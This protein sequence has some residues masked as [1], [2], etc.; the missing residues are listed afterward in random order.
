MKSFSQFIHEM[1]LA[2]QK[3][4]T[5]EEKEQNPHEYKDIIKA[6]KKNIILG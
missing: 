2:R 4:G 3:E 5:P 1:A 6:S